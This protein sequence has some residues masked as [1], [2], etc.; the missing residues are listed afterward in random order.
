MRCKESASKNDIRCDK[1]K[2]NDDASRTTDQRWFLLFLFFFFISFCLGD[3]TA[4]CP[5]TNNCH[6]IEGAINIFE[7]NM[8]TIRALSLSINIVANEVLVDEGDINESL[9][10][11]M[12]VRE[13]VVLLRKEP[14]DDVENYNQSTITCSEGRK[15]AVP[16]IQQKVY[17]HI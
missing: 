7:G 14:N 5:V 12:G 10:T 11:T 9:L 6:P 2:G 17:K 8:S 15:A 3:V 13:L 1:R 4:H 16:T